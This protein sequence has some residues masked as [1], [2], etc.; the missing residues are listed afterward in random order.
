[1]SEKIKK[2]L[3]IILLIIALFVTGMSIAIIVHGISGAKLIHYI[4]LI[5]GL[6][7]TV[8]CSLLIEKIFRKK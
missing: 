5:V 2:I 6:A 8:W 7:V 4:L 3:I 1:M